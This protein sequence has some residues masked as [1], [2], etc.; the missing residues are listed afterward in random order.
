MVPALSLL[1][2]WGTDVSTHSRLSVSLRYHLLL[3]NWTLP[4]CRT[5]RLLPPPLRV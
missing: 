3:S 2:G 5:L 4:R 1:T